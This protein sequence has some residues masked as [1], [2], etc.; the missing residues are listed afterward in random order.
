MFFLDEFVSPHSGAESQLLKLI[1]GL[2]SRNITCEITVLR[3]TDYLPELEK[4]CP[5]TIL[6]CYKMMSLST[7]NK[8][9]QAG[10]KWKSEG[11]NVTHIL[12]NDCSIF[13]PF[14]LKLSR[15]KVIVSRLDMGFWYTSKNLPLL[16]LSRLFVDRVLANGEAVKSIVCEKEGYKPS[17]CEIIYNGLTN[18]DDSDVTPVNLQNEL[19]L[20][21]DAKI[22]GIVASIYPI[23]RHQDLIKA[24]DLLDDK[25]THMV[26]LG[27]GDTNKYN[28]LIKRLDLEGR[29][30][31]VGPKSNVLEWIKS[32]DIACLCSESEG[33]SNALLEYM[34]CGVPVI[35]SEVGGNPELVRNDVNGYLY[36][37]GD[38]Q[39]LSDKLA[40]TLNDSELHLALSKGSKESVDY[41]FTYTHFLDCHEALYKSVL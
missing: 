12:L 11:F 31:F 33:F 1:H 26:A 38:Y 13:A 41:K 6:H 39:R 37:C 21:D 27:G 28:E 15:L 18:I 30:H 32:F 10:R 36:P 23:K 9:Y 2:Q 7:C 24:I 19:K 25:N 35:A 29:I 34:I 20:P 8:I 4:V 5:V 40:Q 22:I 14:F 17:Q 16:K 3:P